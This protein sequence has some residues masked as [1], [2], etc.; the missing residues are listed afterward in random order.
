[1]AIQLHEA[2]ALRRFISPRSAPGSAQ[3]SGHAAPPLATP[4]PAPSAAILTPEPTS[5]ASTD[6]ITTPKTMSTGTALDGMGAEDVLVDPMLDGKGSDD[7]VSDD[8]D[9][10]PTPNAFNWR[11]VAIDEMP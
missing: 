1:M 3:I 6:A 9:S 2:S 10:K 5:P 4:A 8:G 11:L 7:A